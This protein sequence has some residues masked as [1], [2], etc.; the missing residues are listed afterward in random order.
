MHEIRRGQLLYPFGVGAIQVDPN[1]RSMITCGLDHWFTPC[2]QSQFAGDATRGEQLSHTIAAHAIAS[3]RIEEILGNIPLRS[4]PEKVKRRRDQLSAQFEVPAAWFPCWGLGNGGTLE[5]IQPHGDFPRRRFTQVRFAMACSEGHLCEFPWQKWLACKCETPRLRLDDPGTGDLGA[6]YVKCDA[7]SKSESM[8]NAVSGADDSES[9]PMAKRGITCDGSKPWLG[10]ASSHCDK[11]PVGVLVGA[12]NVHFPM[13]LSALNL[14]VATSE[15]NAVHACIEIARESSPQSLSKLKVQRELEGGDTEF[16]TQLLFSYPEKYGFT[17]QA[18]EPDKIFLHEHALDRQ[19]AKEFVKLA[20]DPKA[21]IPGVDVASD[22]KEMKL[23]REELSVL[24]SGVCTS[25]LETIKRPVP[26]ICEGLLEEVHAVR[27]LREVRAFAGF[28]R[29]NPGRFDRDDP[30]NRLRMLFRNVPG[31]VSDRWIPAIRFSGE[32]ILVVLR[33]EAICEW[34]N[35]QSESIVKRIDD[36]FCNRLCSEI[37]LAPPAQGL[38]WKWASRYMLLHSL[39]HMLI[40]SLSF[41][42]GY[43]M[44]SIRERLFVSADKESPM[45]AILLYTVA[46][47]AGGTTGGLVAAAEAESLTTVISKALIRGCWCS[48]D[49]VC[50]ELRGQGW[51]KVNHAACQACV[52][53][54][55]TSCETFNCGLDRALVV[56]TPS[57]RGLGFADGMLRTLMGS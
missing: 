15:R 42:S 52:L 4:P 21:R 37:H 41:S 56:G 8:S 1:G 57:D 16:T 10:I 36:T 55:E 54:P 17:K 14:P 7:C 51:R 34:Q 32:G 24:R 49:P 53:L 23:R 9:S 25:P 46:D 38:N 6:I 19:Q 2:N 30:D 12:S 28:S 35:R 47:G 5:R 45:A 43:S 11:V 44:S 29:L 39:S 18:D 13:I 48:A 40:Q 3:P 22:S 50:S 31:S 26:A 33:E 20:L 27:R